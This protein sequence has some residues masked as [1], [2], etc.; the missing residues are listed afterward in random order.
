MAGI[1]Q[2]AAEE[3]AKFVEDMTGASLPIVAAD[4]PGPASNLILIGRQKTNSLIAD[5]VTAGKVELSASSPGGDGFI[6][7]TVDHNS[8]HYLVLGGSRGRGNLYAVYNFLEKECGVG[9]FWDGDQAPAKST[10]VFS[11]IDRTEI[12]ALARRNY[13]NPTAW[14]YTSKYWSTTDW[15]KEFDWMCKRKL[16]TYEGVVF[17]N[18]LD[19]SRGTWHSG[20][21]FAFVNANPQNNYIFSVWLGFLNYYVDPAEPYFREQAISTTQS[22]KSP[23]AITVRCGWRLLTLNSPQEI[24]FSR[25]DESNLTGLRV[26]C[27]AS[28]RWIRLGI[29]ISAVGFWMFPRSGRLKCIWLSWIRPE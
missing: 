2:H 14:H 17:T 18:D 9:F 24:R 10:L 19:V 20:V 29:Y 12:P 8:L 22:I 23:M 1:D 6:V 7:K 5:L 4:A 21:T 15:N 16:N 11:S 28:P 3:L 25:N 27:S 26:I 13:W